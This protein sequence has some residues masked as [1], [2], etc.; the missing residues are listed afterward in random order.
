MPPKK[1]SESSFLCW[2][3]HWDRAWYQ[4]FE[5]YQHRLI[6]VLE[7]VLDYLASD[8]LPKFSLDGQ[9]ALLTDASALLPDLPAR[10]KPYLQNGRLHVGPWFTMP[11]TTLVGLE[12]L[13]R[14]LQT[15]LQEAHTVGCTH[16]TGYLPDTFGQPESIP[17]LFKKL[18]IPHAMMWRGRALTPDKSP[19]F[20][21]ESPNGEAVLTYQLPE[22]YFHMPL[23]EAEL[24]RLSQKR[25][26]LNALHERLA[27]WDVPVFLPLGG[28]HLAPPDAEVLSALKS[29]LEDY[30]VVHPHEFMAG[31]SKNPPQ[32][33]ERRDGELRDWGKDTAPLLSG[34]L[35]SRPWL[36]HLNAECEWWLTQVW[37]PLRAM[38]KAFL[39]THHAD[40]WSS[41]AASLQWQAEAK[42][43]E[44][45]WRLLLLNHPHDDICGCSIDSVHLQN[46]ARFQSILDAARTWT[47]WHRHHLAE[48]TGQAVYLPHE[49]ALSADAILTFKSTKKPKHPIGETQTHTRLIQDWQHC[50]TEVPLSHRTETIYATSQK[51]EQST[52][53]PRT[54]DYA[55]SLLQSFVQ[56]LSIETFTD[57]GDSYNSVPFGDSLVVHELAFQFNPQALTAMAKP[58]WQDAHH[59]Q[60]DLIIHATYKGEDVIE[61][62]ITHTIQVPHQQV[63]LRLHAPD[64]A[65]NHQRDLHTGFTA[66]SLTPPSAETRFFNAL[67]KKEDGEW[68]AVGASFQGALRW[69]VE[70]PESLI[71]RGI[72]AYEVIEEALI[73]P[74][75][76]GFSHLSGGRLPTRFY[77]A[78]P[79]FETPEGQG[80]GRT[81]THRLRWMPHAITEKALAF[82]RHQLM[83]RPVYQDS[84]QVNPQANLEFLFPH[85]MPSDFRMTA[86]LWQEDWQC[87]VL[88]G[89]NVSHAP[90]ELL[91]APKL[92]GGV[93]W[94]INAPDF[95]TPLAS[96]T[97]APKD[98]VSLAFRFI[99]FKRLNSV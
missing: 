32:S 84:P 99:P 92:L 18:G 95:S 8:T 44:T 64:F 1:K 91:F 85:G 48:A 83:V 5:G 60:D 41:E 62:E 10:L 71:T 67:V 15:G 56:R 46:E 23:Q 78:G 58:F 31:L 98:W 14:N 39:L 74:L 61:V 69:G 3:T 72:Y 59:K 75:T 87:F 17:M 36:K 13:L 63:N 20:W 79:P 55:M 50:I 37:E 29:D 30:M 34:T 9:T 96:M 7:R 38:H 77:P 24:P 27:Q 43:L 35:L 42:A 49:L 21:W 93:H 28:D 66:S 80:I 16:F 11:D 86:F 33:L 73:L 81:I 12:S 94:G 26:A 51:A 68:Q 88:R 76:R 65:E 4:P 53:S 82:H 90:I 57:Q 6:A 25:K 40:Q 45:A 22:G 70:N 19:L 52:L 2:H 97:L 54:R 89:L 47:A